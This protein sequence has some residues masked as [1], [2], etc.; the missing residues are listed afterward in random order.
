[1]QHEQA[2]E[3]A[4]I[5]RGR[6]VWYARVPFILAAAVGGLGMYL[7]KHYGYAQGWVTLFACVMIVAYAA[8]VFAVPI[9]RIREDQLADNC[10]YLGFLYTLGSLAW[11]LYEF[12]ETSTIET[13]VANFGI[14]LGSTI[15]GVLLRVFI[16]Q[17]RRDVLETERDARMELEQAVVRLRTE[18]DDAVLALASFCRNARQSAEE[19]IVATAERSSKALEDGVSRVGE[20]SAQVLTRI[21]E[22]FTEFR[23]HAAALNQS[24]A[25]TVK[26]VKSLLTRI[27]KIDAPTDLV[28]RRLEPALLAVDEVTVR[29]AKWLEAD[30]EMLDSFKVRSKELQGALSDAVRQ[31]TDVS[32]ASTRA[33][34]DATSVAQ[35]LA[36]IAG[37]AEAM[38]QQQGKLTDVLKAH[39]EGLAAE[40]ERS[41]RLV[42][43]TGGALADLADN[44]TERLK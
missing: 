29:L 43:E 10:Y 34:S 18:I 1:M 5:K 21:D 40:L 3:A 31:A 12:A 32:G 23:D 11:A 24:S 16:N 26:A 35:R 14:A 25:A 37:A 15:V 17:A 8:I 30:E 42:A 7:L 33:A 19:Q 28:S 44:V 36:T 22:A 38:Q 2:V 27:E 4:R 41:R 39:N 6:Y 13:I 20:A 9:L